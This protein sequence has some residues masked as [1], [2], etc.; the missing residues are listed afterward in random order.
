MFAFLFQVKSIFRSL[1]CLNLM[2][3][4]TAFMA[5]RSGA[6]DIAKSNR[7]LSS[8]NVV[9]DGWSITPPHVSDLQREASGRLASFKPKVLLEGLR[10]FDV[11]SLPPLHSNSVWESVGEFHKK[12]FRGDKGMLR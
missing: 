1:E 11:K 6:L 7:F 8:K 3:S 12:L 5:T 4:F 9:G 2:Y 10:S